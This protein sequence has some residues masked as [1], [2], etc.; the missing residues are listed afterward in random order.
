MPE[1]C[2]LSRTRAVDSESGMAAPVERHSHSSRRETIMADDGFKRLPDAHRVSPDAITLNLML[3]GI[4]GIKPALHS[5]TDRRFRDTP[6][7]VIS[8][9]G[10]LNAIDAGMQRGAGCMHH[11][12]S[13]DHR[14]LASHVESRR[15][16]PCQPEAKQ[17]RS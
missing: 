6:E 9:Q 4:D 8:A 17:P 1:G 2:S 12:K 5:M 16:I 7:T 3:S 10:K 14:V 13:S 15:R 11:A